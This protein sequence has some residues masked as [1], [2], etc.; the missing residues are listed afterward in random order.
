MMKLKLYALL[1]VLSTFTLSANAQQTVWGIIS[2]SPDHNLLEIAVSA[3]DLDGVLENGDNLTVFA[4]T[5]A[6]FEALPDGTLEAVLADQDL[7]TAI[8]TYHVV[9]ATALST[10]L[11]DGQ[12][13]ETLNGQSVTVTIND[14]GVFINDAQVILADLIADN[15]VVHVINAVLLPAAET[16]TVMDIIEGSDVH[17]LLETAINVAGLNDVLRGEGPFTVFAP[18]DA[19]FEALPEG[20]LEA[21]L[22]DQDL[23]TAI[24]TYHVVGATALST[25]L[26][27]GQV[28]ETLNGQSVTVTINDNGVFINDAQV[29]LAD[30][31]AD[32][33]VVHVI[34]AVLIPAETTTV[35]DIIEESDVHTL[36][37]TAINVAGLNE[38]L[39]GEGPFTVFAPTDAAF[40]ALP[41]G[42]LEA[43]LADQDLLTAIL[44]YHVVGATALSTDLVDGQVIETLNGQSVTVTINDN[45]VFINDA[46]VILA[47]LIADNGVVHV[48][49]AVLLPEIVEPFTVMD[50]IEGSDVHTLLETAIN[51][52]GLN[53][54]LRGEGPFTVFAPTDAAFEALPDGTLEAVL[55]DQDLLTA[56]LTYHVV[57]ATALSTDLVDGQVIETLNGQSVTVTINDNGVFINDAQVI[58]ADLIADNG[59][60]HVIDAVLI[61]A[62]TTTVMDIIEDSDVHTLLETAINVAGLNEVLR[63]EG[64]FTVFAPTDAAFEALPDGTLEAVLADQDLLTAILTYHVVGATALSTDL[65]DG[66]VIETLNGQSVT[67]TIND[68][69][70]FINDAQVILADLIADN[71]VVHVIDAVLLPEVE[72]TTVMDI[73]ENSPDHLTLTSVLG[74]SGLDVTLRGDGPFTVFAPTDNAINALPEDVIA[75]VLA[76]ADLLSNVLL[77]HVLGANALST[78]LSNGQSI[79]TLNGE[80]VNVSITN[81]GIFINQARV[82]VAD[83]VA[84][85]GVVHV[86]DA[87]LLPRSVATTEVQS[88]QV[89][90][91]PNP[92]TDLL[93]INDEAIDFARYEIFDITGKSVQVGR[94]TDG[95]PIPVGT[96]NSGMYLLKLSNEKQVKSAKF[97]KQ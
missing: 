89:G 52:A 78:D 9:G 55:A 71:G 35:M 57:G 43:V 53:D 22:A 36:L 58:L 23:L 32:N 66:Q 40:E 92:A 61:P 93:F 13:I 72:R 18:T 31:I 28:I 94:I 86:I 90:V 24:L 47:D 7:L 97:V 14:N 37:E 73:I 45:G 30:L 79:T 74:L 62:E 49:D 11:V 65:V 41:D 95:A 20:T 44:T 42:T 6:A 75:A 26:V 82:T 60:V 29:I 12:V 16:T 15:G 50:I 59:V 56:I 1:L 87:V 70:V 69:G 27:D 10:D 85:N 96:I 77:Y 17:T 38:V 84:D 33:G 63:G 68:N 67:V 46:Q 4:P 19:A 21:V 51:V 76:D 91:Y 80:T 81:Q 48:I 64:P 54:V 83:L 8:L 39:R 25:D 5:D 2:S 34:D 88:S 3:A